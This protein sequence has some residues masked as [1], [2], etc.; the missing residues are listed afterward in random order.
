MSCGVGL[1]C[2]LGSMLL[3]LWCRLAATAPTGRLDWE[4][5]YAEGMALK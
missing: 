4:P 5:P 1:W 2:K 3:W